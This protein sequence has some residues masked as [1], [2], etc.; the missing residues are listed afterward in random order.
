MY[1]LLRAHG[2]M[3]HRRATKPPAHARPRE[4]VATDKNQVW[5]WDITYLPSFVRGRFFYLYAVLDLFSRKLVAWRVEER[6]CSSIASA[7]IDRACAREGIRRGQLTLHADNGTSQRSATLHARLEALGV[8]RSFSRPGHSNDNP[9]V[10]SLFATLKRRP[11]SKPLRFESVD[12][13]RASIEAIVRWYNDTHL[14]GSIGFVTPNAR[15]EGRHRQIL[16]RRRVVLEAARRANPERWSRQIRS[17]DPID[18][19]VL[20]PA[21]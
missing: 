5:T 10:E 17:L 1:R 18:V 4:L 6:E 16:E 13:A 12:E 7:L 8:A 3:K 19:V 15:H 11:T 2:A 9:F 20:N 21:A 14:H